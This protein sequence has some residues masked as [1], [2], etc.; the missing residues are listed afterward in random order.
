LNVKLFLRFAYTHQKIPAPAAPEG[1]LSPVRAGR[2][3]SSGH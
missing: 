2:A 3:S 1:L